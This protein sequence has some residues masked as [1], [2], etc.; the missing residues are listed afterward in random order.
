MLTVM[1]LIYSDLSS[2][3]HYY[4]FVNTILHTNMHFETKPK[5]RCYPF[6]FV[7]VDEHGWMI[8]TGFFYWNFLELCY[9]KLCTPNDIS[10]QF[11]LNCHDLWMKAF[12][13][14]EPAKIWLCFPLGEIIALDCEGRLRVACVLIIW[15]WH[16]WW[17]D[18]TKHDR[19]IGHRNTHQTML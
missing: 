12:S 13:N 16:W 3:C 11:F 17:S 15:L 2:W 5:H 19:L 10:I 9:L 14:L 4:L 8:W 7:V 18:F 6:V 1:L